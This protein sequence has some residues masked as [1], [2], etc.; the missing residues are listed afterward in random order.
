MWIAR[1]DHKNEE[2]DR[3][4]MGRLFGVAKG[5]KCK[6]KRASDRPQL[7]NKAQLDRTALKIR[8]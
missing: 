4:I 6:Q 8:L 2:K 5:Q 1:A 7:L 3:K